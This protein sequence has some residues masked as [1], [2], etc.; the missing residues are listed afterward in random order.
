M[1]SPLHVL[2]L[3]RAH[4]YNEVADPVPSQP[5]PAAAS[6]SRVL[7]CAVFNAVP[8]GLE[9]VHIPCCGN[10]KTSGGTNS[11]HQKGLG[12]DISKW[13]CPR[14]LRLNLKAV[15]HEACPYSAGDELILPC[16]TALRSLWRPTPT[17]SAPQ[18]STLVSVWESW[19]GRS[20]LIALRKLQL[21]LHAIE[22]L[23]DDSNLPAQMRIAIQDLASGVQWNRLSA[24]LG[25]DSGEVEGTGAA[26]SSEGTRVP[27]VCSLLIVSL[28]WTLAD[29]SSSNGVKKKLTIPF[30]CRCCGATW[31]RFPGVEKCWQGHRWFCPFYL[32]D[33][34]PPLECVTA[35]FKEVTAA[36]HRSVQLSTV[37]SALPV[38]AALRGINTTLSQ[39][40]EPS[41]T[42]ESEA[43]KAP[44]GTAASKTVFDYLAPDRAYPLG[45]EHE[46]RETEKSVQEQRFRTFIAARSQLKGALDLERFAKEHLAKTSKAQ[47]EAQ[48]M[49]R[50]TAGT[51]S[52]PPLGEVLVDALRIQRDLQ[53]GDN[54]HSPAS[55]PRAT[56]EAIVN[57]MRQIFNAHGRFV[58][59]RLERSMPSTQPTAVKPVPPPTVVQSSGAKQMNP[60]PF[61][62]SNPFG[63]GNA[64]SNTTTQ[65]PPVFIKQAPPPAMVRPGKVA[66]VVAEQ[67]LSGNAANANA[68]RTG[69]PNNSMPNQTPPPP[70]GQTQ[71][72]GGGRNQQ[73]Q[74]AQ[75]PKG[76]HG[77]GPKQP[78]GP[79]NQH[80]QP[81]RPS[82]QNQ[83]Q[84]NAGNGNPNNRRGRR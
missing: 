70:Q 7:L 46:A 63:T 75:H 82:N 58:R 54:H 29:D 62:P 19:A 76:P 80:G 22:E 73:P 52:P 2:S 37:R 53:Q 18:D 13:T 41:T 1:Y 33:A 26:A 40:G 61:I 25:E 39:L 34:I 8:R 65:P 57:D 79:Q 72:F 15:H 4:S 56:A 21:N 12:L 42:V 16:F 14:S 83:N 35:C 66:G 45:T 28:G 6:S 30:V 43:A 74:G 81:P 9:R 69:L 50:K 44:T 51:S 67:E 10:Y 20:P 32:S 77:K 60:A 27:S 59:Q 47:S 3:L 64:Q 5:S 11:E 49:G 31:N 84:N 68:F 38:P 36:F 78:P 23:P 24:I 48:R 55:S 71:P 17:P